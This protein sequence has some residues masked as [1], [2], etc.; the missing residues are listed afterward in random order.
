MTQQ[1]KDIPA[2]EEVKF[3]CGPDDDGGDDHDDDNDDDD[4]GEP[5]HEDVL[6]T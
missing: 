4:E 5:G 1:Q 2:F 3:T 6:Q